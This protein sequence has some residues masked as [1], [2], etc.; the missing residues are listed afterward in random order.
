MSPAY[1]LCKQFGPRSGLTKCQAWSGS[2]L[3]DTSG[4]PERF[5]WKHQLWKKIPAYKLNQPYRKKNVFQVSDQTRLIRPAQLQRLAKIFDVISKW[6]PYW[7]IPFLFSFLTEKDFLS[8]F[9]IFFIYFLFFLEGGGGW[10]FTPQST[11]M[12]M[13]GWSVHLT[14]LF[15]WATDNN[16]SGISEREENGLRN[17]FMINL[18]ESLGL[19]RDQTH[20][21]WICSQTRYQLHY[22][23]GRKRFL[24]TWFIMITLHAG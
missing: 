7:Y 2:K 9:F 18:Q 14:T 10:L 1:N 12:V 20:D 3:F 16:P 24:T 17:F 8:V 21:P 6:W 11:A 5:V 19:D 23:V 13:L 15:S 4:I 22:V